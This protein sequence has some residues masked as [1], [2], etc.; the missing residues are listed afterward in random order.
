LVFNP[1]RGYANRG[2]FVIDKA[3]VVQFAEETPPGQP[4]DQDAWRAAL[5]QL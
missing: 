1:E 4:R 2:T 5:A 3:G